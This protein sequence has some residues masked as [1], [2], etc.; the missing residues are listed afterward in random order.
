MQ[1][2]WFGHAF[3]LVTSGTGMQIAFDPFA[4]TVGYPLPEVRAELVIV[5]HD[6]YDHNNVQLVKGYREV[7]KRAGSYPQEGAK[8]DLFAT[9]QDEEKG[10]KRG[11]NLVARV[12]M[13]GLVVMHCGDL[14]LVPPEEEWRKWMP[15]D[16]LMVP[17]GGV[18]TI[19]HRGARK[20]VEAL[21]PRIVIPMHYKTRYLQFELAGVE[22]FLQEFEAARVKKLRESGFEVTGEKLPPQ[23]EVWVLGA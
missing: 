1:V 13:E 14:G 18:Y 7:L 12:E 22:P 15:V 3:F 21:R 6:H 20:L 10:K 23:T 5:S 9:Y 16:I 8:I 11:G 19:D 2:K 4:D 17:V